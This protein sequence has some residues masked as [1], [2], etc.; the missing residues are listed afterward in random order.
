MREREGDRVWLVLNTT[1]TLGTPNRETTIL[2]AV[3]GKGRRQIDSQEISGITIL[4]FA[5]DSA[6]S[7]QPS[8][9]DQS[10][11]NAAAVE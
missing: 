4:L 11:R 10:A 8:T 3:Y 6:I 9:M 7:P 1:N 2:R 5:R